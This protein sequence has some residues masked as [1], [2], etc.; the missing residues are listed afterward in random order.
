MIE[1]RRNTKPTSHRASAADESPSFNSILDV[2]LRIPCFELV[3]RPTYEARIPHEFAVDGAVTVQAR[4]ARVNAIHVRAVLSKYKIVATGR[5]FG[6][7]QV[8]L[9]NVDAERRQ[10]WH[11]QRGT[12]SPRKGDETFGVG[13]VQQRSTGR[14]SLL[15]NGS[16]CDEAWIIGRQK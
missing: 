9:L 15:L 12:H 3:L 14:R 10:L 1:R 2:A 13:A 7:L 6:V 5:A 4:K 11:R 8:L 16:H